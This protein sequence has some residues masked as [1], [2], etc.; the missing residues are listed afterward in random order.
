MDDALSRRPDY[1]LLAS[2][3]VFSSSIPDLICVVYESDG[4]C[5]GLLRA[6]SRNKCNDLFIHSAA[7]TC[8]RLRPSMKIYHVSTSFNDIFRTLLLR[9]VRS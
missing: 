9:I 3:M 1:M 5:V 2:V 4:N 8:A 6:R 7:P